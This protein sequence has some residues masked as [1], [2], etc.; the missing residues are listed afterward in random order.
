MYCVRRFEGIYLSFTKTTAFRADRVVARVEIEDTR[1]T[2]FFWVGSSENTYGAG[3]RKRESLSNLRES[4]TY[5]FNYR[6][7]DHSR[8]ILGVQ[9]R[10]LSWDALQ[11]CQAHTHTVYHDPMRCGHRARE[12]MSENGAQQNQDAILPILESWRDFIVSS[13]TVVIGPGSVELKCL[14]NPPFLF[15][16]L[17]RCLSQ[18]VTGHRFTARQFTV[19]AILGIMTGG[20]M[21]QFRHNQIP[22]KTIMVAVVR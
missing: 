11:L 5:I 6:R 22:T 21:R 20:G 19:V 10:G 17:E 1:V 12:T 2:T 15:L 4:N 9:F 7:R 8:R 3:C 16:A 18:L 14:C 13:S